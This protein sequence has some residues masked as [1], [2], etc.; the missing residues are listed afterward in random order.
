MDEKKFRVRRDRDKSFRKIVYEKFNNQCCFTPSIVPRWCKVNNISE[1]DMKIKCSEE[2][3]L[4]IYRKDG[5]IDNNVDDNI[6]LFCSFHYG[7]VYHEQRTIPLR[8]E[9]KFKGIRLQKKNKV[10]LTKEE[11]ESFIY[12][13][14]NITHQVLFRVM[15]NTGG[16]VNEI[17]QITKKDIIGNKLK[18]RAEITKRKKERVVIIPKSLLPIL[19]M[20]TNNMGSEDKLFPYTKQRVWQ[21]TKEYIEKA[22]IKKNIS[23]HCFRHS[24]ATELYLSTGDLKLIQDLLGHD[25]ISSTAIYS[26]V[27]DKKKEEEINKIF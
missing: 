10:V 16:R 23:P 21:L 22:G 13:I 18:F 11:F 24:Y 4:K 14:K 12:I 26:H 20:Y 9:R 8:K 27:S 25:N 2:N 17:I 6:L 3:K 19:K 15:M 5:N 7:V 1:E